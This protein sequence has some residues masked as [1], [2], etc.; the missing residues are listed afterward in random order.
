MRSGALPGPRLGG[1]VPPD[2]ARAALFLLCE[3]GRPGPSSAVGVR[4]IAAGD[5]ACLEPAAPI[6]AKR[7]EASATVARN[8]TG[9]Y[10]GWLGGPRLYFGCSSVP[11]FLP[12]PPSWTAGGLLQQASS[13]GQPLVLVSLR[14]AT[15]FCVSHTA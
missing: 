10:Y 6:Y 9:P 7:A 14:R 4:S 12:R 11:R 15:R 13:S 1:S 5:D 8:E 3:E 2:F